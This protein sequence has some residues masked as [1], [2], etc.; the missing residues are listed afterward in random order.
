MRFIYIV[1]I[2]ILFFNCAEQ[3][4][5]KAISV[6]W[7]MGENQIEPGVYENT[8]LIVNNSKHAIS[9]NWA[10]FFNQQPAAVRPQK[11]VAISIEQ[12]N[13]TYYKMRPTELYK[14][15]APGDTAIV[16]FR[17]EGSIMKMASAPEGMYCVW[18]DETGSDLR[19]EDIDLQ[20]TPFDKDFQ[21]NR[22]GESEIPYPYGDR[23]YEDNKLFTEKVELLPTDIFPSV[24]RV[25]TINNGSFTFTKD[26]AL[27][28]DKGLE[29]EAK[30]LKEKLESL[31]SCNISGSGSTT[32]T[33]KLAKI[34]DAVNTEYYQLNATDGIIE[35]TGETP[36]A[37]FNG[38]QTLLA[39]L[40][41][42]N[43]PYE[44]ANLSISDY[45]DLAHRGFMLDVARNFSKKEKLLKLIDI[46][47]S[48]KVNVIHIHITD[49]EAWR[50]EIP[51]LEELTTVGA[52]RGHTYDEKE[53]MFPAYGGGWNP[54]DEKSAASGFYT[55]QDFI[56]IL[57]YAT[58][59][60]IKVIPE[61]DLPGHA[62]AAIKAMTA[63]YHKYIK[64]DKEKA[65]E[66]LLEDFNDMS[67]YLSAQSYKDNVV[68]VSSPAVY[69][70]VEKVVN[71]VDL[72]YKEAGLKLD[73]LHLGGDE[74]AHGAWTGSG[75]C[76][77]FMKEH[78]MTDVREL[79]DYF[80]EKTIKILKDKGI[81]MAAWQEVALL[82]DESVNK[83]FANDN[84]LSYCWNTIP[85]WGSDEIPYKLANAGY[86]IIL[87]NVSN[88]YF[89]LSYNKHEEEPGAYWGGF[90]NEFSPFNVLPYNIYYSIRTDMSG[91]P[92]DL[93]NEIKRKQAL[94]PESRNMIKG[95]QAQLWAETIRNFDMVEHYIFPKIFGLAERG[96]NASPEWE[97]D[98]L[99]EKYTEALKLYNAKIAAHEL[100]YL[101]K[102]NVDFRVALPGVVIENGKLLMNTP[103]AGA[104]VY[105]TTDG[106]IPSEKSTEWTQPVDCDAKVVRAKAFYQGK[107]SATT[108][109]RR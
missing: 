68:N 1:F 78:N 32:I 29:S 101:A 26:I 12:I 47:S 102:L 105:Y 91:K 38:T 36:H 90:V 41:T 53:V 30:L 74:V 48:Y 56:D 100:P 40:Q 71:E 42:K 4:N 76:K 57:N 39:M 61:I 75:A 60:H 81:Q 99:G 34:E 80:I 55:R 70:F 35:I 87:C 44:M 7:E 95:I 11:D 52:T 14:P 107:A 13:S 109:Y 5:K 9:D 27:K 6:I 108:L 79:K 88:L 84:V 37:I 46:L 66:F 89:D 82:P 8:F 51:G 54:K 49:D 2:S 86:P 19:M 94:K 97:S 17:C 16:T 62:R 24:K 104:R 65:E 83:K 45:P 63:R 58:A 28:F 50:I 103:L 3:K 85:D 106:S 98:P 23:V 10:I 21:W 72:M 31:Y 43:L 25:E 20:I 96:W 73:V 59:R 64:T 18:L 67:V 22:K 92:L 77:T 93:A 33:L 69:R 15:I